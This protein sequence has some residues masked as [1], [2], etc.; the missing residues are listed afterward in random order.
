MS[1]NLSKRGL[2]VS[3]GPRGAK[4]SFGLIGPKRGDRRTR[5]GRGGVYWTKTQTRHRESGAVPPIDDFPR[6]MSLNEYEEAKSLWDDVE[7]FIDGTHRGDKVE[8]D[9]AI[10]RKLLRMQELTG[11]QLI[12]AKAARAALEES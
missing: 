1:L 7:P 6:R 3:V 5:I 4:T 9:E 10:V 8:L 11:Y 2:G 12:D